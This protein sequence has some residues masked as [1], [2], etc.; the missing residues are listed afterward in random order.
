MTISSVPTG[1]QEQILGLS[2]TGLSGY[3]EQTFGVSGTRGIGNLLI[4][5]HNSPF[6][7]PLTLLT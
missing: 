2:G 3:Q 1:Y 4:F 6:L 7:N 5:I